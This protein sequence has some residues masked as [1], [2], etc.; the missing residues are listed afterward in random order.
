MV[1]Q[2][3]ASNWNKE[4]GITEDYQKLTANNWNYNHGITEAIPANK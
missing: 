4:Y 2:T 1:F 3:T